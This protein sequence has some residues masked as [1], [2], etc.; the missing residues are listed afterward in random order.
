MTHEL[1]EMTQQELSAKAR[2]YRQRNGGG[3]NPYDDALSE[4]IIQDNVARAQ[5]NREE[6]T[7][8]V[9]E[10]RRDDWNA[11]VKSG[12][13]GAPGSGKID[14]QAIAAQEAAQG[15]TM[16]ELK[17]HITRHGL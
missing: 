4:R 7:R 5:A 6:W 17:Q 14:R 8:E 11:R 1:S 16:N 2:E 10:Q 15:W 12:Q 9:T 3:Y 13:F